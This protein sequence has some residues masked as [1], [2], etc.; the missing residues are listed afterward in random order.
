MICNI[1]DKVKIIL[2]GDPVVFSDD[3]YEIEDIL[4]VH[5]TKDGSIKSKIILKD[6]NGHLL[7]SKEP[8]VLKVYQ[9]ADGTYPTDENNLKLDIK[10]NNYDVCIESNKNNIFINLIT[11]IPALRGYGFRM[12]RDENIVNFLNKLNT[13]SK[14]L[15]K[16]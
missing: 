8:Y 12:L 15:S 13:I 6:K 9:Y 11:D 16:R 1:G 2:S 7:P 3:I 14:E 5:S 10:I 4:S